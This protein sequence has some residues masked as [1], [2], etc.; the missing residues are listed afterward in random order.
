MLGRRYGWEVNK[1][2]A[3]SDARSYDPE[4]ARGP[5]LR[6]RIAAV[7]SDDGAGDLSGAIRD[8]KGD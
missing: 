5:M 1:E 6:C 8:E 2:S 7:D 3:G 4:G